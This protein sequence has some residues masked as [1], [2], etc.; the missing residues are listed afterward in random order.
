MKLETISHTEQT[1]LIDEIQR[2]SVQSDLVRASKENKDK[3]DSASDEEEGGDKDGD[4]KP[5]KKQPGSKRNQNS[6]KSTSKTIATK[7]K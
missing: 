3:G 1:E 7:S 6:S 2:L 4:N 5:K